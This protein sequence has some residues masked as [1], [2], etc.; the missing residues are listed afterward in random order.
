MKRFNNK[1]NTRHGNP[2]KSQHLIRLEHRCECEKHL[3]CEQQHRVKFKHCL[4]LIIN[5]I[6]N[7]I[8]I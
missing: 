4:S 1:H 3:N 2:H 7:N 5:D 6:N 8:C